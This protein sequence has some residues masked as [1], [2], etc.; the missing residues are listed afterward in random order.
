M[1]PKIAFVG[2]GGTIASLGADQFDLLDY[3]ASDVRIDAAS[4][5]DRVGIQGKIAEI[6]PVNFRQIDSTALTCDDWADLAETCRSLCND[7]ELAGIVI[8]HGT[9][10]LE[11][12]AWVL[13]LVLAPT[14]PV[15]LTGSMR[16][17]TGISTDANSNLAAAVR[18]A[19]AADIGPGV[20]VV[21][22][23]EI[24]SPRTVTKTHTLRL[25]AFQSPWAGPLGYVDGPDVR[26]A[27]REERR[28]PVFPHA[29]LRTLPR[30]D[31]TYS[32]VGA[33]GCAA[34]AFA[35]AGARGIISAG[36]GPGMGTPAETLALASI[37]EAGVVVV[38]SS[39]TGSGLVVD[40][41][42]HRKH[43]I[44]AGCDINPQRARI[45]LALCLARGDSRDEIE[46]IFR[47][48]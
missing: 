1:I 32:Y 35:A 37:V 34:Y 42:H 18:V 10:S 20:F 21:V 17:L 27:R 47:S 48:L 6:I 39:R 31:V 29:L 26:I 38:Q 16:P 11:E 45:L 9:A 7:P 41:A 12:T 4:L 5:I 30:V 14:I 8:G 3:N 46:L 22:N 36:F 44:I 33:D 2:T 19:S 40:S 24:H 25:G 15:I 13:S 23:D 28:Y 43:G